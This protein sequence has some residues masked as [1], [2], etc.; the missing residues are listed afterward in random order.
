MTDVAI[1][2]AGYLL[3]SVPF[4]YVLPRL[5]RGEDVRE[6]GSGNVGASNVW[7]VY[8]PSLGVPV[9]LLDVAKG[10]VPAPLGLWL[11]GDWVGVLAGAAAMVGHARPVFLGFSK[12]GKMVATAGGVAFALAPLAGRLLPRPLARHLRGV[13][14]RVG[15]V[16]ARRRRAPGALLRVR[17]VVADRGVHGRRVARGP[18]AA[19]AERP[20]AACGHRAAVH[21]RGRALIDTVAGGK[22][23]VKGLVEEGR[24]AAV[25][26]RAAVVVL[27]SALAAAFAHGASAAPWCGTPER[28]DRAP[29]VAGRTI[30]VLYVDPVRR[31]RPHG[32]ARAAD[33]RGRG[34]DRG[35]V[36]DAG[37]RA[38]APL[39]PR[40][41]PLRAA[42]RHRHA[43][44]AAD[45]RR[46]HP[47]R[48]DVGSSGSPTPSAR[49]PAVPGYEKHLVY[50]DGPTDNDRICGEGGERRDGPGDRDRLPRACSGV[51]SARRRGARAPPRASVP[52]AA[53]GPPNACPDTRAHPCDSDLD[54]LYPFADATPLGSLAPRLR[55]TTT[56]ATRAG[57]PTSRTPCGCGS[58]S[59][60]VA[61][62][63]VYRRNGLRRERHPR[64]RLHGELHD[65]VGC[66]DV[67]VARGAAGEGQRFVRWSG[68]CTGTLRCEVALS[69]AARSACS[70]RQ[71]G[72]G[73]R[74][75]DRR[76]RSRSPVPAPRVPLARCARQAT[77]YTPLRLRRPPARDWRF[78]RLERRAAADATRSLCTLPM[79]KT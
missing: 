45:S 55:R 4:G 61:L 29:A 56:T 75:F 52:L 3:G 6:R 20:S 30:R 58:S 38:R 78:A 68:S 74:R 77:S 42:G 17:G 43:P 69:A 18:R 2:V 72:S 41:V 8:G 15:L 33:Q 46:G 50:Y 36:A 37:R 5:V 11:G 14:L 26:A 76:R 22:D 32:R 31:H 48:G 64:R 40:V 1:V 53:S 7:R 10:F 47:S 73:S 21:P 9:A 25:R 54:I 34:R 44:A 59:R 13:P 66:G 63:V 70:S 12:G 62:D 35:V 51:P 57:G 79:T 23:R 60:Q 19:P 16:D 39:R 24:S 65:R 67:R 71:S 28:Q 49:R 27:A